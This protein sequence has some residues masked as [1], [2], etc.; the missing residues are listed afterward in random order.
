[1]PKEYARTQRVGDLIQQELARL[2]QQEMADPR[3]KLVT[4]TAVTVSRDLSHA[5][6]Y[7]T[8]HKS[9]E[10]IP[11]TLKVLNKAAGF[12][13]YHLA[14]A[15]ELRIIPQL[16]FF[17]DESISRGARISALIDEALASDEDKKK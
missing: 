1:M 2:L 12:L 11:E 17:N 7:I 3:V 9:D 15:I 13:R 14:Q 6:I 4:V 5:K 10:E 16:K 8:Q